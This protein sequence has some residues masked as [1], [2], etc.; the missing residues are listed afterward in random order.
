MK[1]H[2]P[3]QSALPPAVFSSPDAVRQELSWRWR[4]SACLWSV[5]LLSALSRPI[6]LG[7][8]TLSSLAF[9]PSGGQDRLSQKKQVA[10]PHYSLNLANLPAL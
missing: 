4:W 3:L 8:C 9:R 10:S 2:N 1:L 5:E 6:A 7:S